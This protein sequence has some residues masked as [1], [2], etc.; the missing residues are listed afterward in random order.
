MLCLYVHHTWQRGSFFKERDAANV[1]EQALAKNRFGIGV[2]LV[3]D[4]G[5][6]KKVGAVVVGGRRRIAGSA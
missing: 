3:G 2:S 6:G 1:L 4:A 5:N